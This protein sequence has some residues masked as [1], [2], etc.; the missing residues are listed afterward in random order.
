MIVASALKQNIIFGTHT[1]HVHLVQKSNGPPKIT[2]ALHESDSR[3][4]INTYYIIR[5]SL[6]THFVKN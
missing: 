1:D 3:H 5:I 6:F 4:T 2:S